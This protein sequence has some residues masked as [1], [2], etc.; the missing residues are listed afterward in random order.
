[1]ELI[2]YIG[3]GVITISIILLIRKFFKKDSNGGCG[4]GGNNT[5]CS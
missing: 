5:K 2:D 3:I 1:M 4:C